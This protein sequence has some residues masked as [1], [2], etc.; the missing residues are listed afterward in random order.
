MVLRRLIIAVFSLALS[1]GG[2]SFTFGQSVSTQR[3]SWSPP[4][5][6]IPVPS[7]QFSLRLADLSPGVEYI[8]GFRVGAVKEASLV[9]GEV[10]F[11]PKR[12]IR[13]ISEI[14][15]WPAAK[16]RTE[17]GSVEISGL[18]QA[19]GSVL[20]FVTV[21]PSTKLQIYGPSGTI[22]S[23]EKVASL[24]VYNGVTLPEEVKG[25][26]TLLSRLSRPNHRGN[27]K[28]TIELLQVSNGRHIATPKGI[29]SHL[30]NLRKPSYPVSAKNLA[31]DD[32]SVF[33][34]V[35]IDDDGSV[36]QIFRVKG[37]EML[38]NACEEAI[39]EW[40]FRPFLSD[41]RPVSVEA[42]IFF[43]FGEDGTISSPVFDE[44]VK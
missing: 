23:A 5:I 38:L 26:H 13:L 7:A 35:Q 39:R 24:L 8:V 18:S 30:M 16:I 37:N 20:V 31:D 9:V 21:P 17:P 25:G 15:N 4:K 42:S 6:G 44:W 43:L 11:N 3:V 41:G 34:R 29:A 19:Q 27:T 22:A 2:F 36:Q 10:R 28:N 14:L 32:R 40:R 1:L 33:L 12:P